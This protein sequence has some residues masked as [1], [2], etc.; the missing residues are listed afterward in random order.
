LNTRTGGFLGIFDDDDGGRV[1]SVTRVMPRR[2]SIRVRGLA[3]S[4]AYGP[5]G[6]G[7]Y[8]ALG[9]QPPADLTFSCDVDYRGFVRDIDI[10]RR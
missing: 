4:D 8:G 10:M 5:Y 1:L 7:A 6:V 2:N 9:Y 3:S